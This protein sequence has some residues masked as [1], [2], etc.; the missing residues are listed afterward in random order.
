MRNP[1][2]PGRLRGRGK[3]SV[4]NPDGH[5]IGLDIGATAVR[6]AILSLAVRDGHP[7]VTMNGLGQV[8]LPEGAVVNGVVADQ[9]A[10]TTALKELWRSNK[11]ACRNVILGVTHQQIVVRGLQMPTLPADQMARALPFRAREIIALPLERAL[12]DFLPLG[13]PDPRDGVQDG[14][15]IAAPREPV[16]AAVQAVT[17]AGL[18]VA[19]VD[20]SCFGALRS[21]AHEQVDVEAVI[22]M[23]AHLTAIVIHDHGVPRVV[24]TVTLGGSMLTAKLAELLE[25]TLR[26][27]E[28]AKVDNGLTGSRG[29]VGRALSQSIRPLL[30]EIRSSIQ[31]FSSTSSGAQV[32]RISL[33]GGASAL[34][35]LGEA[36]A[37]QT[38]IPVSV[39][40]PMEHVRDG[41]AAEKGQPE[42]DD[43][44]ATAVSVGL[45]M[46]AAA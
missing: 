16:L 34:A 32:E 28:L 4:I 31:Y 20:L 43:G 35:G 19:R 38:G 27:A 14:L 9:A 26:D 21:I 1:R 41:W 8:A 13:D 11:F 25:L 30:A 18:E 7:S 39:V 2:G 33:T 6:A 5:A 37:E 40:L 36:L 23:G 3:L 10:V 46:G 24:R 44:R 42:E 22:D 15:L 45:A 12:I 29:E 17:R